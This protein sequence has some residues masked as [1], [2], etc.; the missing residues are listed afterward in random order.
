MNDNKLTRKLLVQLEEM[1]KDS[2]EF[3]DGLAELRRTFQQHVR[4]EKKELLPAVLKA[5][6][7]EET[8][9]IVEGIEDTKAEIEEARRAEAEQRRIAAR[10]EREQAENV[11]QTAESVAETMATTVA[12]PVHLARRTAETVRE[13]ARSSLDTA[14]QGFQSLTEQFTNLTGLREAEELARRSFE[15][16]PGRF[17]NSSSVLARGIQEASQVWFALAQERLTKS[18]ESFSRLARCR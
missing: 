13:N 15:N 10:E 8:Q 7:D 14:A 3:T 2:D 4:D 9:A 12:F 16:L 1:P 11:R 18:V 17:R 5:L 6:S